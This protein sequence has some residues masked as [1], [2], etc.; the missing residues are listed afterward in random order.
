MNPQIQKLD[1]RAIRAESAACR[2][3]EETV[4]PGAGFEPTLRSYFGSE[5]RTIASLFARRAVGQGVSSAA[6]RAAAIERVGD[7]RLRALPDAI[8]VPAHVAH[9]RRRA[10]A[11]TFRKRDAHD[12][13]GI[14]RRSAQSASKV[15]LEEVLAI[16]DREWSP[17]DSPTN[18]TK[19]E[20]RKAG[21]EQLE[22]F[23][24]TYCAAPAD[25]LHQEKTFR[26]AA[27]ARRGRHRPHGPGESHRR[28]RRSRSWIT[29]PGSRATRKSAAKDL[30][31][32]VYAL[33]A[34]EILDLDPERLVFYNL[35][36]NEPVATTRDAKSLERN[37][38]ENCRSGGPDSRA[39]NFPRSPDSL[40]LLRLQAAVPGARAVDLASAGA[41][42]S[43]R[44]RNA[45]S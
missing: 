2:R 16:Y 41:A 28:K 44:A 1:A 14:R 3:S 29:R 11:L 31:L 43:W 21:R 23:H 30:Q 19:Q 13:Q 22:A 4:G 24:K 37:E 38:T 25:V 20:Y 8:H 39:A 5:Q 17:P 15:P 45:D 9:S 40:R 32:S 34:R 7:W 27:R 6:S 36:T 33:A 26:V 12:D 18:I 35:M 10:R 42:A